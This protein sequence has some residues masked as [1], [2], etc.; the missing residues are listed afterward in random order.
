MQEKYENDDSLKQYHVMLSVATKVATII[1][2]GTR[3]WLLLV[4]HKCQT[5]GSRFLDYTSDGDDLVYNLKKK[6]TKER[7]NDF[8][9]VDVASFTCGR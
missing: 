7:E 6:A 2:Y 9:H 8:A 4:H 3:T 5:I 1:H